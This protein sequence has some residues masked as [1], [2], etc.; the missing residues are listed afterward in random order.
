MNCL[1]CGK[2][3]G[4]YAILP[5]QSRDHL[6]L[7]PPGTTSELDS[8]ITERDALR[9]ELAALKRQEPVAHICI[10]PTKDAGLTKFFTAPS[11]PRGFAVYTAPMPQPAP[12]QPHAESAPTAQPAQPAQ[13]MQELW[14]LNEFIGL[15]PPQYTDWENFASSPIKQ[16]VRIQAIA[17][18]LAQPHA[19]PAAVTGAMVVAAARE[20]CRIEADECHTDYDDGWKVYGDDFLRDARRILGA[21]LAAKGAQS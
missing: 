7:C 12:A 4:S 1:R 21:A 16:G 9:A 20:L 18:Q 5:G 10:L 13:P 11:D 15:P 17:A 14:T 3:A 2:W 6:C 19:E 8:V